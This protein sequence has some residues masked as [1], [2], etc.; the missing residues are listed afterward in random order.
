MNSLAGELVMVSS[1]V[2]EAESSMGCQPRSGPGGSLEIV[3]LV[4]VLLVG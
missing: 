1:G 2:F 4:L 3:D